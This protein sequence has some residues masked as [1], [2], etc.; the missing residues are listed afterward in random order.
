MEQEII[1]IIAEVT[2]D[3]TILEN[4]DVDLFET[5]I[6]DSLAFIN[7]ITCIEEKYSIE[8]EPTEI[9]YITWTSTKNISKMIEEKILLKK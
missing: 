5:D 6:L 8:I 4:S 9:Q 2:G 1:K 3:D 7:L